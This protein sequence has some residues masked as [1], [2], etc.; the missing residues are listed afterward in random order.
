MRRRVCIRTEDGTLVGARSVHLLGT[1]VPLTATNPELL[2]A[3]I[4]RPTGIH[5]AIWY[6]RWPSDVDTRDEYTLTTYL[7]ERAVVRG[8]S[9]KDALREA[10][11]RFESVRTAVIT[12]PWY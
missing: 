9:L 1:W 7:G 11:F 8:Y 12:P 10:G 5:P 3:D 2:H 6:E 4:L